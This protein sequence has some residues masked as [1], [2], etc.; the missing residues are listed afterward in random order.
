[1][2]DTK[3][4]DKL[5]RHTINILTH[6]TNVLRC[7]DNLGFDEQGERRTEKV[8]VEMLVSAAFRVSAGRY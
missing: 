7:P 2:T 3:L 5:G 8:C 4:L 6:R 1:M